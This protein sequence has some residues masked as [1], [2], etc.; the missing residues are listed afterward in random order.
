VIIAPGERTERSFDAAKLAD[1]PP[2]ADHQVLSK[3]T[4]MRCRI[5]VLAQI[6][7]SGRGVGG[8]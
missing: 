2:P 5:S 6:L 4:C 8:G 3:L 7:G 1:I